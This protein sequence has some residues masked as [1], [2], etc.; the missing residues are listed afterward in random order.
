VATDADEMTHTNHAR[1]RLAIGL[2]LGLTA[3][4]GCSDDG[5]R[6]IEHTRIARQSDPPVDPRVTAQQRYR[7]FPSADEAQRAQLAPADGPREVPGFASTLPEGWER[8]PETTFRH[9]NTR[10]AAAPSA[11]CYLTFLTGDGGGDIA[12]V[13]RWR[14]EMGLP[15]V[16]AAAVAALP[17]TSLIGQPAVRVDLTGSFTGMSGQRIEAARLLGVLLTR[18]NMPGALFVKFV[19]PAD[20]VAANAAAFDQFVASIEFV[21]PAGSDL[22]WQVPEG[23]TQQAVA[24]DMREVTLKKGSAELYVSILGGAG[25]G[26]LAN[27]NRWLGQ[28]GAP[29]IGASGLAGLERVP[30][31]GGEAYLVSAEGDFTGMDGQTQHEMGLLGA[32]LEQPSRLVT[33]KLVGTAAEVRAERGAF[34][35]F[36]ASLAEAP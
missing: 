10:V 14:G 19:G 23:W 24:G 15:P 22:T 32:I 29:H 25:G 17:R 5:P 4:A 16:D 6:S 27:V 21:D 7:W 26:V 2:A 30:C 1:A 31:L 28:L 35:S 11:E 3:L 18:P 34:V 9:I 12:N 13:N 33:V 36:V 8:V 20:V